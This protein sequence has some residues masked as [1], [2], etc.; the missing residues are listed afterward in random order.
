MQQLRTQPR[1]VT[2]THTHAFAELNWHTSHARAYDIIII[3]GFVSV[4]YLVVAYVA[5]AIRIFQGIFYFFSIFSHGRATDERSDGH[6]TPISTNQQT[7]QMKSIL[8]RGR[9]A[10]RTHLLIHL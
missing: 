6:G 10:G 1:K 5:F 3:C 8:S 9:M 7:W 4:R 2:Q